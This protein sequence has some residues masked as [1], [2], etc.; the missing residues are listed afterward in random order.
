MEQ[1]YIGAQSYSARL[2]LLLARFSRSQQLLNARVVSF[3]RHLISFQRIYDLHRRW[4]TVKR[5]SEKISE[6]NICRDLCCV[7]GQD[8]PRCKNP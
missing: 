2:V 4:G 6:V 8:H 1:L 3:F 7:D 5:F